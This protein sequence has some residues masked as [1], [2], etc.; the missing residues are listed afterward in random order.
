MQVFHDVISTDY[1]ITT[2]TSKCRNAKYTSH[3]RYS[4][5]YSSFIYGFVP[6]ST[7]YEA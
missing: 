2:E 1:T 7:A 6:W 5:V 4:I 3:K